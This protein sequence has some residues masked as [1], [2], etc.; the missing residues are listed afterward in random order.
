MLGSRRSLIGAAEA[1]QLPGAN[2]QTAFEDH[3]SVVSQKKLGET[4]AMSVSIPPLKRHLDP[5]KEMTNH[6]LAMRPCANDRL[7]RIDHAFGRNVLTIQRMRD[8][9]KI[10]NS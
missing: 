4:L 8:V 2:L 6:P 7:H 10:T 5:F 3:A 9:Q 1:G